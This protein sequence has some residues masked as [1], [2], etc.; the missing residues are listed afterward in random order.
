MIKVLLF[1]LSFVWLSEVSGQKN[2]LIWSDAIDKFSI[3]YPI[4][5]GLCEEKIVLSQINNELNKERKIL[6]LN[7]NDLKEEQF[8]Q[9]PA[10]QAGY[11]HEFI[12]PWQ[13]GA[14][15]LS[16]KYDNEQQNL[17]CLI[18]SP[19]SGN[20][21]AL[22]K[23]YAFKTDVRLSPVSKIEATINKNQNKLAIFRIEQKDLNTPANLLLMV[24]DE[25]LD[26]LK[27]T[28]L[29]LPLYNYLTDKLSALLDNDG[30]LHIL[31]SYKENGIV[32]YKIFAFPVMSDDYVEYSIDLPER[33][34]LGINF[35]LNEKEELVTTGIYASETIQPNNAVGVFYFRIDRESGEVAAK[36]IQDFNYRL[37]P[38][39]IPTGIGVKRKDFQGFMV[40]NIENNS[41]GETVMFAEQSFSEQVCIN[42]FRT[43]T[44]ICNDLNIAGEILAVKFTAEGEVL[45]FEKKAKLQETVDEERKFAGFAVWMWKD[46]ILLLHNDHKKNKLTRKGSLLTFES[47]KLNLGAIRVDYI[48]ASNIE[49]KATLHE[50]KGLLIPDYQAISDNNFA[51]FL[52]WYKNGY[53]LLRV[54]KTIFQ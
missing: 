2:Q 9:L 49:N 23:L 10:L 47:S 6:V 29:Q 51:I 39:A 41:A 53:R 8:L 16:S 14:L 22:T 34:I 52:S 5:I 24:L 31:I 32:R 44:I 26:T 4:A 13:C 17:N 1:I 46:N 20:R 37:E 19:F 7:S 15:F 48:N 40:K 36:K 50:G 45:W 42:D 12:F 28:V 33:N 30:N 43:G 18:E 21:K 35:S 11:Q 38:L 3:D 25:Q 54:D 27:N